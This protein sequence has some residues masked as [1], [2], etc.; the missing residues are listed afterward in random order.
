MITK[1]KIIRNLK[2]L[3]DK[4]QGTGFKIIGL[5]GSYARETND[6]FSDV[7]LT[8]SINHNIFYKDDAFAKL[9][10]LEEIKNE[11]QNQFHAK[12]DL[13]P[14][15]TKNSYLQNSLQKDQILI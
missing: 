9:A 13:I 11:L 1:D 12:V 2:L 14:V 10:K 8:Y 6:L 5:F 4:Y 15:N 3:N 7:D